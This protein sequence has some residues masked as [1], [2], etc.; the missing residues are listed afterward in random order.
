MLNDFEVKYPG[1]KQGVINSFLDLLPKL[2]ENVRKEPI[3]SC[4]LCSEP[5]NKGVC[6]ACKLVEDVKNE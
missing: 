2:K 1:T 4:S 5:A 3:K 6:N